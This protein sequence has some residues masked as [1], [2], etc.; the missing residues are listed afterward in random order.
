VI[1]PAVN[2]GLSPT[3][4]AAWYGWHDSP[5]LEKLIIAWLRAPDQPKRKQIAND[6]QKLVFDE[7][8]YVPW[9]EWDTPTAFRKSVQGVLKF[10]A[11][12]FWNVRIV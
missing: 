9:G 4:P 10:T 6:I 1:S 7:V 8:L 5:Q 3:G 11:P 2:F 12:L